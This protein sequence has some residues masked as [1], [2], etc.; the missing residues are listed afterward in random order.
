MYDQK[1]KNLSFAEPAQSKTKN[2]FLTI[3][4]WIFTALGAIALFACL[5]IFAV[6]TVGGLTLQTAWASF[7]EAFE[8]SLPTPPPPVA[9]VVST[10]TLISGIQPLGQLVT[11]SVE[12]AK[13]DVGIAVRA[14]AMNVCGHNANHVAQG[15]IEAGVDFASI[16]EDNIAYNEETDTYTITVNSPTITSCRIDYIRQYD[17]SGGNPTCGID[18]DSLRLLA[19]YTTTI[20]FAED[21]IDEG[22]LERAE[23]ESTVLLDSFV[24]TLTESNVEIVY[25]NSDQQETLPSSCVPQIPAGWTF[26]E[27]QQAWVN[28]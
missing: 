28:E 24:T 1:D 23:S 5:T 14:G 17:R 22:I 25:T 27:E 10:D 15:T 3:V 19:Q 9:E 4:Q 11:I 13:A 21:S 8:I 7:G 18:W 12:V 6:F 20:E 26:N 2:P 16:T